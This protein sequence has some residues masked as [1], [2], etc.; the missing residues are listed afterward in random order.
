MYVPTPDEKPAQKKSKCA[1]KSK[2]LDKI[3]A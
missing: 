2:K 3:K 1:R